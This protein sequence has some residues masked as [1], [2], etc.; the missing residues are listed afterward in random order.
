MNE[1][2]IK[3]N[4]T[5]YGREIAILAVYGPT[6]DSSAAEKDYFMNTLQDEITKIK[7]NYE[8]IIAGDLNGRVGKREN[9]KTVGRFGEQISNDNGERLIDLCELNDLKITNGFFEHKNIRK[10]TWTQETRKL[11]SII[12]YVKNRT[13]KIKNVRVHRGAECGTCLL[14]TSRCV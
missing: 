6:D 1:R 13:T 8:I 12:D 7:Q 9:D 4:L 3:L 10:Y 2:I 5:L 11:R 14:Y